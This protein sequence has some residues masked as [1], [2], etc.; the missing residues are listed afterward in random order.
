MAD[1]YAGLKAG[2]PAPEALRAAQLT[3][4]ADGQPPLSWAPFILIG[5]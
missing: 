2:R 5:E 4:I 3:R 1:I